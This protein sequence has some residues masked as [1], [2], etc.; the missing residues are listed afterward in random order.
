MQSIEKDTVNR[1]NVFIQRVTSYS[2]I[3]IYCYLICEVIWYLIIVSLEIREF[4]TCE[5]CYH[6]DCYIIL[7]SRTFV[8]KLRNILCNIL[9]ISCYYFGLVLF[10]YL[11]CLLYTYIYLC[12][13]IYTICICI[14]I[15]IDI[16]TVFILYVHIV[17]T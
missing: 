17:D 12:I 3:I 16:Y 4:V 10:H 6:K 11:C 7:W 1:L 5:T 2:S 14:Y 13:Y 9:W 8:R 15:Y